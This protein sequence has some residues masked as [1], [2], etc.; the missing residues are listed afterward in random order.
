MSGI[1]GNNWDASYLNDI[2]NEVFKRMDEKGNGDG[3]VTVDEALED[4]DIGSLLAGQNEED[5]SK[6]FNAAHNI[7]DVLAKYS[8][9]DGEF[10]AT[11]WAD[12]LN[13]EEWDSV[14][15]AWH[16]SGRKA[17]L[18]MNWIDN[19]HISDGI[20]TKGEVKVGL[21]NN[22]INNGVDIDTTDIENL[23]DK[24]A[25]EDG[26]LTKEEYMQLKQ[27]PLYQDFVKTY[28]I[29]PWFNIEE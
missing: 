16:S 12:F 25:S 13:G 23:I 10:S 19:A 24:Y 18:E 3:K 29:T 14:L 9:E 20:V 28:G 7:E 22:L 11:E 8:G 2:K 4:L 6:I 21:L 17:E 5:A 1:N 27:D 15:D 26:V